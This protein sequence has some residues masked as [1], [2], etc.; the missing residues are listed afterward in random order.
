MKRSGR[1]FTP[2]AKPVEKIE[3]SEKYIKPRGILALL[4]LIVGIALMGYGLMSA[5]NTEPTWQQIEASSTQ[6]HCGQDFQLMYDFSEAEGSASTQEKALTNLYSQAAVT[7]YRLFSPEYLEEGFGNVAWLN[8]HVNETVTLESGLYQAL[9]QVVSSGDRQVFLAPAAEQYRH[10]FTSVTDQ[11]ASEF[12]PAK[13]EQVGQWFSSLASFVTDPEAVDVVLYGE[14]QAMLS[15]SEAYL[16]FARENE[17][18]RF[19]DFGWMTN[20]FL[21]DFLAE[22]LTENGFTK[23][24]VT[25]NDGFTRN[26]D[27]NGREYYV[28]LMT[29]QGTALTSPG[30]LVYKAPCSLVMFHRFSLEAGDS[31]TYASGEA[32]TPYLDWE[33]CRSKAATESLLVYSAQ[34]G[35]AEL[36]LQTA[37]LYT[38]DSLDS[39]ALASLREEGTYG[40]WCQGKTVFYNDPSLKLELRKDGGYTASFLN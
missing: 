26:L 15:V 18:P 37:N 38:S 27:S 35:C 1:E 22:T 34:A 39:V 32:V 23:G 10:V 28:N 30:Q 3:L 19:L 14:N 16:A 13:N 33:D 5:L 40:V 21:A 29:G 7:G 31:Y 9:E 12:D 11:E 8:A 36:L 24:Y 2:R 17:I 25:S 20:A 4:C 6:P